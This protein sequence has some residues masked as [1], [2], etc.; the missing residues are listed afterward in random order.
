MGNSVSVFEETSTRALEASID[1]TE[2]ENVQKKIVDCTNELENRKKLARKFG[3][4]PALVE[5][6]VF[7]V[8]NLRSTPKLFIEQVHRMY[9]NSTVN[10]RHFREETEVYESDGD[11]LVNVH[12]RNIAPVSLHVRTFPN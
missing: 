1:M 10:V 5:P 8:D 4:S 2:I 3:V 9:P 7:E 12:S 11:S 6:C